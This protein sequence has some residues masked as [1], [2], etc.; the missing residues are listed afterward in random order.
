MTGKIGKAT[1]KIPDN[2]GGT[3]PNKRI[4]KAALR[5]EALAR[6]R[7]L[8]PIQRRRQEQ[9]LAA[10]VMSM[11]ADHDSTTGFIAMYSALGSELPTDSLAYD[12]RQAGFK[13]A[14]PVCLPKKKMAFY[15]DSITESNHAKARNTQPN[16]NT[17]QPLSATLKNDP[18]RIISTAELALLKIVLPQHIRLV[19]LPLVA[20][21]ERCYRLG[22][23]Q[24]YYDRYLAHPQ[25]SASCWG[26]A[27]NEQLIQRIPHQ[28]HDVPLNAVLTATRN[29][30]R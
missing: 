2:T 18:T 23:G 30:W 8:D 27:F 14:Y 20:F 24:G 13:L 21:D 6:R 11:L 10:K 29:F 16:V 1:N 7:A 4:N 17:T 12:L 5:Q 28:N 9:A 26:L 15:V 19:L 25:L 3:L 22:Y